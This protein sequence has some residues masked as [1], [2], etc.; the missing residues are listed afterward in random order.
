MLRLTVRTDAGPEVGFGHFMRMLSLADICKNNGW[1]IDFCGHFP[2]VFRKLLNLKGHSHTMESFGSDINDSFISRLKMVSEKSWVVIDGYHYPP[3]LH[4]EI[5]A[6]GSKLIIMD[7]YCHQPSY[8][9]HILVNQNAGSIQFDYEKFELDRVL[10]GSSYALLRNEF[11][12]YSQRN[13]IHTSVARRLL[14]TLG[15]SD[16]HGVLFFVISAIDLLNI[17]DLEICILSGA[18]DNIHNDVLDKVRLISKHKIHVIRHTDNMPNLMDWADI[19]ITGGGST[20]LEAAFMGLPTIAICLADNQR[21]GIEALGKVGVV[22]YENYSTEEELALALEKVIVS[23]ALRVSMSDA[24]RELVDGKGGS[25]ILEAIE[26]F[27]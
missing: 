18:S 11:L 4:D 21:G 23:R 12:T 5:I 27:K 3:E 24:G 2:E 25:R 22:V 7:D 13:R 8:L 19:G 20:L 9:A 6:T 17:P 10:L 1:T 26:E 16:S 15:G 14:V